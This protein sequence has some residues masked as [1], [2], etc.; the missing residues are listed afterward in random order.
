M[1]ACFCPKNC[2]KFWEIFVFIMPHTGKYFCSSPS[3]V[4]AQITRLRDF[5]LFTHQKCEKMALKPQKL[6]IL[7]NFEISFCPKIVQNFLFVQNLSKKK[8]P[9]WLSFSSVFCAGQGTA[10]R[11]GL[12]SNIT[13]SSPHLCARA[14]SGRFFYFQPFRRHRWQTDAGTCTW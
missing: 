2:P 11:P 13:V 5:S 4:T 8:S 3:G 14:I 12:R 7:R 1:L 9:F 10:F 6:H